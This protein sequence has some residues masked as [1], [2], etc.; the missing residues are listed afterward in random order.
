MFLHV[1]V[2]SDPESVQKG[3]KITIELIRAM[4]ES[5]LKAKSTT[6]DN[7]GIIQEKDGL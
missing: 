7:I 5:D 3:V 4:V 1:P 6:G 2:E